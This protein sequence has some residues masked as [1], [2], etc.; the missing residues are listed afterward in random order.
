MP[1]LFDSTHNAKQAAVR[2]AAAKSDNEINIADAKAMHAKLGDLIKAHDARNSATA[3]RAARLDAAL[4]DPGKK[5]AITYINGALTRL[6]LDFV[7]ASDVNALTAAMR[8]KNLDTA[9][10][11]EIKRVLSD[12]GVLD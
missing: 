5:A 2:I 12:L 6:G 10:R 8:S 1:S 3:R 11:I 4:A 9:T 7:S